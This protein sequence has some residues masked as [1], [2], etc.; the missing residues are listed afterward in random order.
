MYLR[1]PICLGPHWLAK[2]STYTKQRSLSH[3]VRYRVNSSKSICESIGGPLD[4]GPGA[5]APRAH[6]L[7]RSCVRIQLSLV[8][9]EGREL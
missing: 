1:G 6:A 5:R 4:R 9:D 8:R 2:V 3:F 7:I